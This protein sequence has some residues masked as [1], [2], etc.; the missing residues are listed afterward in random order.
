MLVAS[1]IKCTCVSTYNVTQELVTYHI[2]ASR[3]MYP[4]RD[5]VQR[6]ILM[7]PMIVEHIYVYIIFIF[8]KLTNILKIYFC[9][10]FSNYIYL[11]FIYFKI[12]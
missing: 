2:R 3:F 4:I 8:I 1:A 5:S 12:I 9:P 6:K 7:I 11:I 10:S